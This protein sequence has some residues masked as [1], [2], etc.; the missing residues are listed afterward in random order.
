MSR[1][2]GSGNDPVSTLAQQISVLQQTISRV[3]QSVKICKTHQAL[4]QIKEEL[5]DCQQL[6]KET[7][8]NLK[9]CLGDTR[10]DD[11]VQTRVALR[12]MNQTF[13]SLTADYKALLKSFDILERNSSFAVDTHTT[14]AKSA[15][16]S[17]GSQTQIQDSDLLPFDEVQAWTEDVEKYNKEI[18]QIETD[19]VQVKEMFQDLNKLVVE[20]DQPLRQI[21]KNL[22]KTKEHVAK[23]QED[24]VQTEKHQRSCAV[25]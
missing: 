4:H 11:V 16:H 13:E 9:N 18:L 5:D 1:R 8:C 10:L 19:V 7:G 24:L 14:E 22:E 25:M 15:P 23:A 17:Y 21:G 20:Q 6:Y 2:S 3:N 12:R